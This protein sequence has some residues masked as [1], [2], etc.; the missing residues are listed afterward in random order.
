MEKDEKTC[1]TADTN[2]FD[3]QTVCWSKNTTNCSESWQQ[4]VFSNSIQKKIKQVDYCVKILNRSNI[5]LKRKKHFDSAT[6][7]K[8]Y[9]FLHRQI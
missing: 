7:L 3:Q 8:N 5:S 6:I 1:F 4:L 9:L 2:D